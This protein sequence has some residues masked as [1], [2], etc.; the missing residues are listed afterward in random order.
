M[1]GSKYSNKLRWPW[2]VTAPPD[3]S[4]DSLYVRETMKEYLMRTFGPVPAARTVALAGYNQLLGRPRNFPRTWHGYEDR[5]ATAYAQVAISH[6]L[7]SAGSRLVDQR[8]MRFRPCR[9]PGSS[10]F[11]YAVESPLRVATPTGVS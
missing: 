9:C 4:A 10:R 2:N 5:L 3:S 8:S 6:T 1:F 11:L 7:R